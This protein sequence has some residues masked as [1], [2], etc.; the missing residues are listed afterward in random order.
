MPSPHD[1]IVEGETLGISVDVQ[2]ALA[3][4][5]NTGLEQFGIDIL[6]VEATCVDDIWRQAGTLDR[7]VRLTKELRFVTRSGE[8][9]VLPAGWVGI[10]DIKTGELRI[11]PSGFL[12]H[13]H[14]YAVQVASYAQSVPYDPDSDTR[15]EWGFD[16]DQ[17]WAII[18]HVDVLRAIETGEAVF[19][20]ILVDLEAGRYAGDLCVKAREWERRGDIFSIP[21]PELA[22]SVT[23]SPTGNPPQDV[24]H[25]APVGDTPAPPVSAVVE[26][27]A[28]AGEVEE[29]AS[30]AARIA[31]LKRRFNLL[32]DQ[33]ARIA[34][35]K[36]RFNL[37]NDQD[38]AK[39]K[40]L[41]LHGHQ[42]DELEQALNDIDCFQQ[43]AIPGPAAAVPLPAPPAR[44]LHPDEGNNDVYPD[45]ITELKANYKALPG[46]G[47][48]WVD[49]LVAQGNTA[50]VPWNTGGR[51]SQRRYWLG[52]A[53][54]ALA[55]V[56][57]WENETVELDTLIRGW[58]EQAA[59]PGIG[60]ALPLGGAIG[61]LNAG[62]AAVFGDLVGTYLTLS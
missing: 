24:E 52:Q 46:S 61:Q 53:I 11:D 51:P 57:N 50:N 40:A 41:R 12:E 44:P 62:E 5:W 14:G 58:L 3:N 59:G 29:D 19:Q 13:W 48:L 23:V 36:R 10:L 8:I 30:P 17:K 31:D 7:I 43:A 42:V 37:L 38:R 16:I 35:L 49:V 27:P 25:L 6:A 21:T 34:D 9:V 47:K 32:N 39:I 2:N 15:G 55:A 4:A 54:V 45:L 1:L 22:V 26:E 20:L 28:A 33:A 18:G 60:I 56:W